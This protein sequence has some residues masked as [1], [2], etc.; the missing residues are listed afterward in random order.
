MTDQGT[1]HT[2]R[3]RYS[4]YYRTYMT[5]RLMMH[6]GVNERPDV[7]YCSTVHQFCDSLSSLQLTHRTLAHDSFFIL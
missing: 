6:E 7:Q 2:I 3:S 1:V 4:V 5:V